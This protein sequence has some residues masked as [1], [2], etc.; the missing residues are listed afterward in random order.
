MT[1]TKGLNMEPCP[2]AT[3]REGAWLGIAMHGM[4]D[5][6]V[7]AR[8]YN[9]KVVEVIKVVGEMDAPAA[10]VRVFFE[11]DD[12]DNEVEW[13]L[14]SDTFVK[15]GEPFSAARSQSIQ[16]LAWRRY[17]EDPLENNAFIKYL[18]RDE[19]ISIITFM[20][21][22]TAVRRKEYIPFEQIQDE[23][24]V[25]IL[26]GKGIPKY[27]YADKK[28][29]ES[30]PASTSGKPTSK[31]SEVNPAKKAKVDSEFKR[32]VMVRMRHLEDQVQKL[33]KAHDA[34]KGEVVQMKKQKDKV[35]SKAVSA[36]KEHMFSK[37]RL[38]GGADTGNAVYAE[39]CPQVRDGK[40]STFP[41]LG[42]GV[43]SRYLHTTATQVLCH[44][45]YM[46]HGKYY[47]N[48]RPDKV[49]F[50]VM[51]I[52]KQ[53]TRALA[54]GA[55]KVMSL[56]FGH[57]IWSDYKTCTDC[58]NAI[59]DLKFLPWEGGARK[60]K[61]GLSNAIWS[62]CAM[63]H[64]S[65][66]YTIADGCIPLCEECSADIEKHGNDQNG[67][68][69]TKCMRSLEYRFPWL[70]YEWND[71]HRW[72]DLF[73]KGGM[74]GP[75]TIFAVE[76]QEVSKRVWIVME[77]DGEGHASY[78]VAKEYERIVKDVAGSLLDKGRG[79]HVLIIRYV[80]KGKFKTAANDEGYEPS[81]AAR[82]LI[83]RSW[84]CWLIKQVL[85]DKPVSKVTMMYMFYNHDNK[86]YSHAKANVP[87]GWE[88]GWSHTFPQDAMGGE[89]YDWR[90]ALNPN[91]GVILN[92]L[93]GRHGIFK[94]SVYEALGR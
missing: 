24:L 60:L 26:E 43:C 38:L 47:V 76:M 55:D 6:K 7:A 56:A 87:E 45:A 49:P 71:G 57:D 42:Y 68:D 40:N 72:R 70:L 91:E 44:S 51:E 19:I 48:S 63:C 17:E 69:R 15:E 46:W 36:R 39:M 86:H 59:T 14:S 37:V 25:A 82:L 73:R 66:K 5:G 3:L 41:E 94:A 18:E 89:E 93:G 16:F 67:D 50:A 29:L 30:G 54:A 81:K 1:V 85:S 61:V 80:P 78:D 34:L 75:D 83:V 32:D 23:H 28:R 58:A 52:N 35:A 10:K 31:A 62:H 27:C 2:V 84:V 11:K 65:K 64:G 77:E 21:K 53:M 33:S 13:L 79:D 20:L 4:E 8:W 90:Y 12:T 74:R 88:I 92:V 22:N 9:C